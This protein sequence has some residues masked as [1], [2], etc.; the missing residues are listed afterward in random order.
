MKRAVISLAPIFRPEVEPEPVAEVVALRQSSVISLAAHGML[1]A[2]QVSAAFVL[3]NLWEAHEALRRRESP[4]ERIDDR[5][6]A[7]DVEKLCEA[8]RELRRARA[9]LGRHG[10]DLVVKVCAEG[11]HVRD[12]LRSRRARD[13][14]TDMLRVHLTALAEMWQDRPPP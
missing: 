2:D 11:W 12:F 7:P 9:L 6:R 8:R 10:Y 3:R 1:N 13:T 5:R 4:L 14:A